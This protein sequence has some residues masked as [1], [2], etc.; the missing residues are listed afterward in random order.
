MISAYVFLIF[1]LSITSSPSHASVSDASLSDASC[2]TGLRILT[3]ERRSVSGPP[4]SSMPSDLRWA[5]TRCGTIAVGN[6]FVDDSREGK[7]THYSHGRSDIDARVKAAARDLVSARAGRDVGVKASLHSRLAVALVE[8]SVLARL[9][10]P[11]SSAVVFGSSS[12]GVEALL[13]AAGATRV[14]T[15]E[16]NNLTYTHPAL[17]TARPAEVLAA[18]NAAKNEDARIG[19]RG[20]Y[21]LALSISSF[22]H[23]GLGRYGDPLAPD[24]DLVAMDDM[25]AYI[26]DDGLA[27]VAVPIGLDVVWWNLMREY[28]PTRLPLLI[29]E[30]STWRI[31]ARV[32]WD[33]ARFGSARDLS[34]G[35]GRPHEPVF[36]LEKKPVAEGGDL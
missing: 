20:S 8:P 33:A 21:D 4:P 28:G 1:L 9:T 32:G 31:T 14:L 30:V 34:K 10:R 36:I 6:F 22:D 23:D 25:A 16:Y 29:D 27:L 26:R 5:Y 15:V 2:P 19:N 11:N 35:P 24:G 17:S 7:G 3:R 12:P 18:W 13:I